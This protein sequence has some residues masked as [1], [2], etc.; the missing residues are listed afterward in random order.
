M[1][2]SQNRPRGCPGR[3]APGPQYETVVGGEHFTQR[4]SYPKPWE[5]DASGLTTVHKKGSASE[6]VL[7]THTP[8]FPP[9]QGQLQTSE[10]LSLHSSA[11]TSHRCSLHNHSAIIK[12]MKLNTDTK[13]YEIHFQMPL[14]EFWIYDP[15]RTMCLSHELIMSPECFTEH[16][17][18]TEAGPVSPYTF[19][20]HFYL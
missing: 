20:S 5:A 2:R 1:Q 19:Y 12:P 9:F 7:S 13:L 17:N 18:I 14:T 15:P 3:E 6:V 11:C 4:I 10:H 16:S 8:L